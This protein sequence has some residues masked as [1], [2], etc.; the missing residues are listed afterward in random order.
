MKQTPVFTEG[1][2]D[3]RF[4][5]TDFDG[6]HTD[7]CAYVFQS[8]V[9][10]VRVN[11]RDGLG[12]DMLKKASI[13]A[14]IISKEKNAVVAARAEKLRIPCYQAVTTGEGKREVLKRIT[15]QMG[16]SQK[17]VLYIGDDIND[18]PVLHWAGV[19]ICPADAH[20]LVLELMRTLPFG[21]VA[22]RRGGEGVIREMVELILGARGL[23][24]AF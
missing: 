21:Y 13:P 20:P 1:L 18:L 15:A 7:G 14:C 24:L 12:Y 5:A 22:Q 4:F 16:I 10:S 3:V 17:E 19:A 9:E 2:K 6:V 11:R 8:G 23:P